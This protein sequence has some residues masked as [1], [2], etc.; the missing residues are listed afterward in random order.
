MEETI[1]IPI[2]LLDSDFRVVGGTTEE[3]GK[4]IYGA[5]RAKRPRLMYTNHQEEMAPAVKEL[6]RME[7]VAHDAYFQ[8]KATAWGREQSGENSKKRK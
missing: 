3:D 6:A 4:L 1:G 5:K 2:D 8:L 7:R